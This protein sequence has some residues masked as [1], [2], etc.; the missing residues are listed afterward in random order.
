[1][2][3]ILLLKATPAQIALLSATEL[4]PGL[5]VGLFA[6]A[7]VDR[8][9]RRPIMIWADI[10]HLEYLNVRLRMT[11]HDIVVTGY[12]EREGVAFIADNDRLTLP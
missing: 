7:L 2:T 9:R 10:G 8:L 5:F 1:M 6:G 11:M 3:A 4:V 12:D